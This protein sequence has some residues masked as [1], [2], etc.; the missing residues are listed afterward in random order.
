MEAER[1]SSCQTSGEVGTDFRTGLYLPGR[2]ERSGIDEHG[3]MADIP[4]QGRAA[5][6]CVI[7][8]WQAPDVVIADGL[9]I[10]VSDRNLIVKNLVVVVPHA[11]QPIQAEFCLIGEVQAI[12]RY[13]GCAHLVGK[14]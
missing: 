9:A 8:L 7:R 10:A 4:V 14:V 12:L 1:K 5:V 3:P 2:V 13:A 11:L 6:E